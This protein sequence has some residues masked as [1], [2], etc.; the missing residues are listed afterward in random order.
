MY[1]KSGFSA[2]MVAL[3]DCEICCVYNIIYL[4]SYS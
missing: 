4:K 3:V 1:N 2:L